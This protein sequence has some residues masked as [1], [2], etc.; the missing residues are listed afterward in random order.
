VS[1]IAQAANTRAFHLCRVLRVQ[2]GRTI[3]EHR[4]EL[5][6]RAALERITDGSMTLPACAHELGFASHS[7]FVSLCRQQL[8]S[9]Q[10]KV[11]GELP[12]AG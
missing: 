12:E 1:G 11:R 6:L 8:G 5:R 3:H 7:H 4:T 2:T 10:G 9:A